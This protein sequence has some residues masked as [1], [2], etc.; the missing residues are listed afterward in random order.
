LWH[1]GKAHSQGICR[2]DL[3]V[4]V[5]ILAPPAT[6]D[7]SLPKKS[8]KN[9]SQKGL[10]NM[11]WLISLDPQKKNE[12][13]RLE[14]YSRSTANEN[15]KAKLLK[16]VDSFLILQGFISSF[17]NSFSTLLLFSRLKHEFTCNVIYRFLKIAD[18]HTIVTLKVSKILTTKRFYSL[19]QYNNKQREST[20]WYWIWILAI[21]AYRQSWEKYFARL[22]IDLKQSQYIKSD[23]YV[24]G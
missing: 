18:L 12:N 19:S 9:V 15:W 4:R 8:Q 17:L 14:Y 24:C 10:K 2:G 11:W 3:R 16:E 13:I 6:F 1:Q 5:R 22:K 7:P 23:P 21:L 20:N